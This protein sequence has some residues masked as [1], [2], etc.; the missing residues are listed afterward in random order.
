M[1]VPLSHKEH[2]PCVYGWHD[3]KTRE[4]YV[5]QTIDFKSRTR[6]HLGD[7]D[8]SEF[9]LALQ[10]RSADFELFVLWSPYAYET[11]KLD[12][13]HKKLI[14]KEI[15]F[16]S[17]K[18]SFFGGYN[19][20]KGGVCSEIE[21]SNY[22]RVLQGLKDFKVHLSAAEWYYAYV[23]PIGI[24]HRDFVV[25]AP[26]NNFHGVPLGHI[27]HK[28]R[29]NPGA[30]YLVCD[31]N[32]DKLEELGF[33]WR[34]DEVPGYIS[35]S[36]RFSQARSQYNMGIWETK[37]MPALLWYFARF[38]HVN[39]P[40]KYIIPVDD[41]SVPEASRGALLGIKV[42]GLRYGCKTLPSTTVLVKYLRFCPCLD[43]WW[44]FLLIEGMMRFRTEFAT[45]HV[46]IPQTFSFPS[47]YYILHLRDYGLGYNI[48]NLMKR[49]RNTHN[50]AE[51]NRFKRIKW[52]LARELI[53]LQLHA[54]DWKACVAKSLQRFIDYACVRGD[55]SKYR[56]GSV[57]LMEQYNAWAATTG[58][59]P[60]F[61]VDRWQFNRAA[62][63]LG[64]TN[65]LSSFAG[66]RMKT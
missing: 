66:I 1:Q 25:N 59:C 37:W 42:S 56:V 48:A 24:V 55:T 34:S 47:D 46:R 32:L 20:T 52:R 41:L 31:G 33:T 15:E 38:G 27:V 23:G 8:G 60:K 9:H 7:K 53:W 62:R 16:I 26:G 5:G 6:A 22:K 10:S 29:Q 45:D 17:K 54:N 28:W 35:K 3:T 39:V 14:S 13:L 43:D 2:I 30:T 57:A 19:K 65:K 12:D 49:R 36:E 63:A 21:I 58:G 50:T 18:N 61:I 44:D 51:Y 11:Y 64:Y 40:Q 4:W